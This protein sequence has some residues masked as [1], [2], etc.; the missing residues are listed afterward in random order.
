VVLFLVFFFLKGDIGKKS[1]KMV[2]ILSRES[3]F[4][5]SF[6]QKAYIEKKSGNFGEGN[7]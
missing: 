3:T 2:R 6:P 7:S 1:G 5:D 4:P